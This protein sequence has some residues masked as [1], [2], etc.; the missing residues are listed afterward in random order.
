MSRALQITLN[1]KD[2]E[3]RSFFRTV[4]IM[5]DQISSVEYLSASSTLNIFMK[6]GQI[7]EFPKLQ[8]AQLDEIYAAVGDSMQALGYMTQN[9]TIKLGY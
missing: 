9:L 5:T 2:F 7:H 3:G 4:V 8:K 1:G 6:S